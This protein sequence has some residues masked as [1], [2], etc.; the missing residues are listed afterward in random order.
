MIKATE[1]TVIFYV[2]DKNDEN[3]PTNMIKDN[4]DHTE[5]CEQMESEINTEIYRQMESDR[6]KS[7]E[8][9]TNFI[10]L[11]ELV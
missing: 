3:E 1:D 7:N 6:E 2:S 5:T 4:N 11:Y 8:G 9:L 10:N